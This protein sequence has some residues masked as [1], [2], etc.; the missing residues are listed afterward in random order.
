MDGLNIGLKRGQTQ[1]LSQMSRLSDK[2]QNR[3]EN[4]DLSE[5]A[6]RY[7]QLSQAR[8]DKEAGIQGQSIGSNAVTIYFNPTYNVNSQ[9][10]NPNEAAKMTMRDFE[11]LMKRYQHDLQRRAY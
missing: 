8:Q 6:L 10:F 11:N 2:L 9:N 1:P 7:S 5:T 3:I 4:A